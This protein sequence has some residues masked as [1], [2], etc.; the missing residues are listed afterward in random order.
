MLGALRFAVSR[1]DMLERDQRDYAGGAGCFQGHHRTK[2][3]LQVSRQRSGHA[4]FFGLMLDPFLS[5]CHEESILQELR[6]GAE[7]PWAPWTG[8]NV[9]GVKNPH[10]FRRIVPAAVLS[11]PRLS[12]HPIQDDGEPHQYGS[13]AVSLSPKGQAQ[14]C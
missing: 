2:S 14:C 9:P 13:S 7:A 4:T 10:G 11:L 6:C 8:Q 5:A 3:D 12:L 1:G